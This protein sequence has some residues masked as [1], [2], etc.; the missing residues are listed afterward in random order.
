M[1][2]PFW[3]NPSWVTAIVTLIGAF[4]TIPDVV[5]NWLAKE[6]EIELQKQETKEKA[7]SNQFAIL[8]SALG[9]IGPERIFVLRYLQSTFDDKRVRDWA[10]QEVA[11]LQTLAKLQATPTSEKTEKVINQENRIRAEAGVSA[12]KLNPT[13]IALIPAI[14]NPDISA[15]YKDDLIAGEYTD[16]IVRRLTRCAARQFFI[17]QVEPECRPA[18]IV[19]CAAK[20]M[21]GKERCPLDRTQID[22]IRNAVGLI[23]LESDVP[24]TGIDED[25]TNYDWGLSSQLSTLEPPARVRKVVRFE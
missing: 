23:V 13:K 11:R 4:T 25:I 12:Q 6:Q 22:A 3:S 5:S 8:D 9:Q 7:Q 17:I 16:I 1:T 19:H 24:I 14:I 2:K 18:I 10:S 15:S 20:N 21:D